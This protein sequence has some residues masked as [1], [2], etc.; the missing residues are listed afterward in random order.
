MPTVS[1]ASCTH[2]RPARC[3]YSLEMIRHRHASEILVV[4][5][6]PPDGPT[7]SVAAQFPGIRYVVEKYNGLHFA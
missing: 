4:D 1:I 6:A 2:D 7:A 3:L 5:N